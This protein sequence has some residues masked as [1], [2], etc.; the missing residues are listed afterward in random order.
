VDRA[1]RL[2]KAM[3]ARFQDDMD[4]RLAMVDWRR[5]AMVVLATMTSTSINQVSHLHIKR[6]MKG[7]MLI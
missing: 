1:V 4:S 2:V 7:Y 6:V 5:A 3:A